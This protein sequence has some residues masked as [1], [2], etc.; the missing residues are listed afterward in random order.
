MK[1]RNR[2]FEIFSLSFLDLI[3]CGFGAVV[4]LVLI[5]KTSVDVGSSSLD[6][7]KDLIRQMISTEQAV[8]E[9]DTEL[10][11]SQSALENLKARLSQ[12]KSQSAALEQELATRKSQSKTAADDLEGLAQVAAAQKK[13]SIRPSSS[14]TRDEEVGGIPTD[15]D[16]IL[17]IVDTSGSMK[18]IWSR[19]SQEMQN[20]LEIHP[21]VKGFQIINDNGIHLISAYAGKWIADTPGRRRAIFKAF[22]SWN[23]TSNSSPVE[24]LQLALKRYARP[25]I[26]LSIY[27]FGDDYTGSSYNQVI[28]ELERE[29]TNRKTGKP[30]AK[31]H[32]IGFI[33]SG[34]TNRFGILM[35]EVTKR[36]GGTFIALPQ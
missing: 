28:N 8:E 18:A 11:I 31:I 23:S 22:S 1:R 32:A 33:S 7:A 36:N 15:S 34:A 24:G 6:A 29:N 21:K 2:Q 30:L 13:S 5:S 4:L 10:A 14:E 12:Q 20:V 3:S 17:F 25:G 19:V 35:R 16:Y 26:S 27:I 9:L